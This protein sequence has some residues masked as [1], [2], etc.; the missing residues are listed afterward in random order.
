MARRR[1]VWILLAVVGATVIAAQEAKPKFEV[2]SVKPDRQGGPIT[3]QEVRAGATLLGVQAGGR[4]IG[5]RVTVEQL[6]AYAY[7]LKGAYQVTGLPDWVRT[8]RFVIEA[9][10][11]A[12]VR[13]EQVK[14]MVQSL[15]ADRFSMVS[16]VEV[17]EMRVQALVLAHTDG[18]LGPRLVR[19]EDCNGKTRRE[20]QAKYPELRLDN[21]FDGN[22]TGGCSP[23]GVNTLAGQLTSAFKETVIDATGLEGAFY[24]RLRVQ[25]PNGRQSADAPSLP[26]ALREQLGLK[27]EARTSPV[28]VL[29]IDSIRQPTDN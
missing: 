9:K 20:V 22:A 4:F 17:R 10:A 7:D 2:T 26:T 21:V 5:N 13:R 11:S 1:A 6:L 29:V 23:V 14:L 24:M 16:H 19:I 15:L 3:L 28:E 8:D 25:M 27:L 18:T 12:D